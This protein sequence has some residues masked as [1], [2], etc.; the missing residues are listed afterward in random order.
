MSAF[1]KL[2]LI[3]VVGSAAGWVGLAAGGK[4]W[5]P[6]MLTDVAQTQ[7]TALLGRRAD[8]MPA[9]IRS[10]MGPII[11]YR[12]PDGLA[13]WSAV[14]TDTVDG[15]AFLPV[16]ASEDVSFDPEAPNPLEA[17]IGERTVLYYRHPMGLPDKSPVPKQDSMGMDYLP[18]FADEAK[19]AG[20]VTVSPG[21]LQR[22]GVRTS[23]AVLKPMAMTVRAPGIVAL[24]ERR[25]SVISLRADAFIEE[26]EYVTTGSIVEAGEPLAMLYSPDIVSA[27]AQY[28]SDLRSGE[29]RV[30]GSRQ[31]LANLGVPVSVIDKIAAD[32]RAPV[33]ISLMAPRSGVVLERMAVEGMMSEAGETLFRIAD[34]SVVWVFADVPESALMGLADGN[35]ATITFPG[36]PGETFSGLIDKIY[37]EVDMQTRTARVRIDLPN[38]EGRLL[39]NMFADVALATGDGAPV[40]QVPETSVI[41]TGDRQVV[42]RDMGEGKFAPQDVVVG[43]QASGMVEIREGIAEGDR[44]VTTSTFLIDAESNLNAAL[45]ALASPEASE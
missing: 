27:A 20:S 15:E 36:L 28:V 9:E 38:T 12:H 26:V 43:R 19:D 23:V 14:P 22:T 33:Q 32:R 35:A 41:D 4:G 31:R 11:Y 16:L 10:A 29:G 18:V 40:V 44:V 24:D 6:A 37:P 5:T 34:T 8:A 25:V 45:A 42:I 1:G 30:E 7:L 2:V 3:A 17:K 13:E 39:V 21:K